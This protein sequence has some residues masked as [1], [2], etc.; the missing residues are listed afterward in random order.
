MSEGLVA[1][2]AA[3]IAEFAATSESPHDRSRRYSPVLERMVEILGTQG[4]ERVSFG[5]ALERASSDL[6]IR[7]PEDIRMP[8]LR[9]AFIVIGGKR[10][11]G[12]PDA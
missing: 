6:N 12:V 2:L 11:P 8:I 7:L 9:S 3:E 5:Q 10:V 4:N 1:L